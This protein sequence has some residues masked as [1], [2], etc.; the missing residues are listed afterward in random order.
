[1]LE[2]FWK[3]PHY[4]NSLSEN[5]GISP[6]IISVFEAQHDRILEA[7]GKEYADKPLGDYY[8]GYNLFLRLRKRKENELL[9]LHDKHVPANNSLCERLVRVY[10]KK[11]KQAVILRS[12]ENLVSHLSFCL[13]DRQGSSHGFLQRDR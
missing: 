13:G 10:K 11:Q 2:L 4:R 8:K 12:Q 6:S 1:M 7:A 5:E 9:F 3:M